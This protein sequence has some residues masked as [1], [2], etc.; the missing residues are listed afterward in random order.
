ME[1]ARGI[2][3]FRDEAK[4]GGETRN[5][6]GF[7]GGPRERER[8]GGCRFVA[9]RGGIKAEEGER[10]FLQ[11]GSWVRLMIL[12]NDL[13]SFLNPLPMENVILSIRGTR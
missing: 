6:V 5:F 8:G 13:V 11:R 10:G 12:I 3:R 4:S 1:K 9:D 7:E 2:M